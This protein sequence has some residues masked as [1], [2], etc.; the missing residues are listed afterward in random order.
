MAVIRLILKKVGK[1]ESLIKHVTDRLGHDRRYAIDARK[2]ISE[3]GWKPTVTFEQGLE[4]TIQW[5][6]DNGDWLKNVVSGDYQKYYQDMY[7]SR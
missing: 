2:I 4:K 1:N 3:L 5:Y 7:G 6:L